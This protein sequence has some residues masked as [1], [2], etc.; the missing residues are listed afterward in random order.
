MVSKNRDLHKHTDKRR[1]GEVARVLLILVETG[2]L[3][4]A[5]QV[6]Y[7]PGVFCNISHRH[8]ARQ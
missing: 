5:V 3:F 2:A 8:I 1:R 6:G 4:A 7:G